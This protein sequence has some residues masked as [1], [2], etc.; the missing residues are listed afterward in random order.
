MLGGLTGLGSQH[1]SCHGRPP[2]QPTIVLQLTTPTIIRLI[3]AQGG[4]RRLTAVKPSYDST[5][6][7]EQGVAR[8]KRNRRTAPPPYSAPRGD[9][10]SFQLPDRLDRL[11]P[12]LIFAR[13]NN[14]PI[15][16][17]R[18]ARRDF[19]RVAR[20]LRQRNPLIVVSCK[21]ACLWKHH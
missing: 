3:C 13:S 10:I 9:P 16:H 2:Q 21:N 11:L 1:V 5:A 15:R 20:T 8:S 12:D 14:E 6:Y 19:Q 17:G 4:V 7:A 18:I